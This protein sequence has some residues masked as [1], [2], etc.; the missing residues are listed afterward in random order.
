MTNKDFMSIEELAAYL[1]LSPTYIRRKVRKK[2]I[3]HNR[4]GSRYLFFKPVIDQWACETTIYV[5][6]GDDS[7]QIIQTKVAEVHQKIQHLRKKD[8]ST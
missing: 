4:H 6:R 8:G 2:E 7:D 1:G 5:R 3:P